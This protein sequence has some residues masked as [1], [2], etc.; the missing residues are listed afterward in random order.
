MPGAATERSQGGGEG[1]WHDAGLCCC[2]QR[3][4]PIGLSPLPAALPLNPFP[5]RVA[6][7]LTTLC[8]PLRGGGGSDQ[9][10]RVPAQKSSSVSFL[11]HYLSANGELPEH[12]VLEHPCVSTKRCKFAAN[13]LEGTVSISYAESCRA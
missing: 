5:P 2:L 4:A 6:V 7:P 12:L 9:H 10:V 13:S 3:A 1:G 8:L 11:L